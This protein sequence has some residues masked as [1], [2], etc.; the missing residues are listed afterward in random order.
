[1]SPNIISSFIKSTTLIRTYWTLS[2]RLIFLMFMLRSDTSNLRTIFFMYFL[3]IFFY[4][5][6]YFI[7]Y[8][9]IMLCFI[10]VSQILY[11]SPVFSI[12][13]SLQ[14]TLGKCRSHRGHVLLCN[15]TGCSFI[16]IQAV[17]LQSGRVWSGPALISPPLS[18]PFSRHS[19]TST[20]Q[21]GWIL[22]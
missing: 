13:L 15:L 21:M 4:L 5:E 3:V 17:I 16:D 7:I 11:I 12:V 18:L 10:C 2:S 14:F 8:S 1:M 19:W 9:S 22:A 20:D 6:V